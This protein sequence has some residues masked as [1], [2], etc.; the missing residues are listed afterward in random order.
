[1]PCGA[2]G[3]TFRVAPL[4]IWDERRAEAPMGTI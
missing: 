2:P 3:I 4:I 1:M